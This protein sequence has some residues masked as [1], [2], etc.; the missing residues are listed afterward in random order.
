VQ[1]AHA[2]SRC[3][4]SSSSP[5]SPA[6][7]AHHRG[8]RKTSVSGSRCRE[9]RRRG[10]RPP[11]RTRPCAHRRRPRHRPE[12]RGAMAS[13]GSRF[14]PGALNAM[15]IWFCLYGLRF[16]SLPPTTRPAPT[17]RASPA[18]TPARAQHR[19]RGHVGEDS[20]VVDHDRRREHVAQMAT[21]LNSRRCGSRSA[22]RPAASSSRSR[23]PAPT[24]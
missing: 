2:P 24:H 6:A 9:I 19:S 11:A 20:I 15:F 5:T 12:Q 22:R 23:S 4:S 10:L 8:K 3:G 18:T 21:M 7:S 17:A 16:G 1:T 13:S 14:S